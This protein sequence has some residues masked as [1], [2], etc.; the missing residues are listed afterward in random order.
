MPFGT[1][2]STCHVCGKHFLCGDCIRFV[3]SDCSRKSVPYLMVECPEGHGMQKAKPETIF[4]I[5]LAC[6][7]SFE[8]TGMEADWINR[9]HTNRP[10]NP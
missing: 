2:A 9:K 5:K 1:H 6:G 3:C 7:C 10:P 4:G 8:S